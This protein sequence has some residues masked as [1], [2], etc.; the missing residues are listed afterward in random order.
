MIGAADALPNKMAAQRRIQLNAISR[1]IYSLERSQINFR[2]LSARQRRTDL[3][4]ENDVMA[5][6]LNKI[7]GEDKET[8]ADYP[9]TP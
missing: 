4:F 5:Q 9:S 1:G 7:V 6:F 8:Q 2:I 3:R